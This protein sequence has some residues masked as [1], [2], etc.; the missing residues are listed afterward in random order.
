MPTNVF[1]LPATLLFVGLFGF[2]CLAK[3]LAGA[4]PPENLKTGRLVAWCIVPFDAKKRG[5][6][7]R[8]AMLDKLG[9]KRLAYDWREEH[10][11]TWDDELDALNRHGIELTAFW[12]S[13]TL[14]PLED[15]GTQRIVRFLQRREISTQLWIMLPDQQL[16]KIK[17]EQERLEVAAE[18]VRQL[19]E[20]VRPL[21]CQ[22]GLYNHG[23]WIGRP[24]TL[25]QVMQLLDGVDNA[26]IVY[27]LH[28]AHP[29][30]ASFPRALERMNPY[31]L[32]LNLNGM[33]P[34]G[35]KIQPIGSGSLDRQWLQWVLECG[36]TGPIG[37]LDH[38]N[39]LDAQESLQQN[40]QGLRQ[41]VTEATGS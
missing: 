26:G 11:P 18:A 7:Q 21:K 33:T 15:P 2:T 27:N 38:R 23:G 30:L 29:D 40:L 14:T 34:D 19:A 8:A 10:V 9:L 4:E 12:C 36:Y 31:L 32:C 39:E 22:V 41:L 24:E 17:D 5:P 35:P 1:R 25:V 20:Q 28:H 13:S 6:E 16:G 37:I 3:P